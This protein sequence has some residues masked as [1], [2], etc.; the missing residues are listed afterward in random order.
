MR[1]TARSELSWTVHVAPSI[2]TAIT[3]LPPGLPQRMW[4]P[5]SATLISGDQDA[6]LVD[7]LMTTGQAANLARWVA[8][9]GKKLTTV[10]I[11]HGHGDHWFGLATILDAF[12]SARAVAVPAV[13]ERMKQ[14]M[15]PEFIASFWAPR[16]PGQIPG[17]LTAAQA[18]TE[19]VIHLEGQELRIVELG[20]TDTDDTTCLH[21]PSIGLVAAGDAVYN[22]VHLYL[23][24]SSRDQREAW[25]HALDIIDSLHPE[26]VIAG[27]KRPGRDDGP[28]TI[29]E[30]RQYINDF[31]SA[32]ART[33]TALELY[34]AMLELHPD[35]V[36]PGALWGS[37]RSAK[38]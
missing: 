4:S 11:T 10:Y 20:H 2:P 24:E 25:L 26:H 37:A 35:R 9:A 12:P 38:G 29:D 27:H 17:R 22:D 28:H 23:A 18:L 6:V 5:I 16:F 32:A 19:P 1:T 30:T 34:T 33:S 7:P 13:V 14:Q 21:V 36:N 8:A 3:D 15:A 31:E